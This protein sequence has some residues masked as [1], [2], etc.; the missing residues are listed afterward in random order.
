M[1]KSV[2]F[3]IGLVCFSAVQILLA[4]APAVLDPPAPASELLPAGDNTDPFPLACVDC[5]LNFVER[6]QDVRLSTLLKQWTSNVDPVLLARA[7][8]VAPQGVTLRGRHPNGTSALNDIPNG[9][10]NCH[11]G[12]GSAPVFGALIHALHFSGGAENHYVAEFGS[13]CKNCHK[14]NPVNGTV[15]IPSGPER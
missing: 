1:K 10:L 7:Q 14:M 11:S 4:Q 13:E 15:T 8:A 12:K 6:Q 9:C 5:H 3:S 2:L